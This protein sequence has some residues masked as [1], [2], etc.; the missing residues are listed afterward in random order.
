MSESTKPA[1]LTA[2]YPGSFDPPHNGH[3]DI[4]TKASKLFDHVVVA[5]MRNPAKGGQ[6]FSEQDR[7][8]MLEESLAHLSGISVIDSSD[9]VIHVAAQVKADV[10]VK[11]LRSAVDFEL[12]MQMAH[13]N[14]SVS[15]ASGTGAASGIETIFIPCSV[16]EGFIASSFIRQIVAQGGD[17]SHLVPAPVAKRLKKAAS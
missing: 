9:L 14:H 2:L 1:S 3:I 8:A 17:C 4:I 15:A 6:M 13:M 16:G 5:A 10:I 7:L 12:E 11:G